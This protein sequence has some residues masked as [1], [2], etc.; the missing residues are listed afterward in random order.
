MDSRKIVFKETAIVAV[1]ELICSG[2]MVGV[3]ALLGYFKMN[4]L[5]G[6]LAGSCVMIVNYFFM[7]VT[8]TLAADRAE[9][10]DPQA[11]QRMV[12]LSSTVRLVLMGLALFLGIKLGANVI[13]L[14]LPLAFQ[15]PILMLAE[16]FRKKGDVWTESK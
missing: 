6:A 4:V 13:A 12:Q 7:A 5:W 10:G 11:G 16:F 15:R 1:G 3:F 2:L 8:V 9:Q 14:V